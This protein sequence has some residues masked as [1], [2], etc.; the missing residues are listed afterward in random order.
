MNIPK[1]EELKIIIQVASI[2]SFLVDQ[3]TFLSS[4]TTSKTNFFIF[5]NI[6]SKTGLVGFE[7]TT[8]GFGDRRS[9][10]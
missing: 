8:F 4:T 10:S 3:E 2:N 9:A 7:P 1:N 5:T 6:F